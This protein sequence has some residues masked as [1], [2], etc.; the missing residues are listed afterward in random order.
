VS[1][2][3]LSDDPATHPSSHL[4]TP[5]R[6]EL[7]IESCSNLREVFLGVTRSPGPMLESFLD[8]ITSSKLTTITFEF[9]W[10]EYSG[11]DI[12]EIVD[13]QGW[14]G[15]DEALCALVD[16]LSDRSGS[17]PLTVVLSVRAKVDTNLEGAKMGTFLEGFKE[18]GIVRMASFKGF[19][20]PVRP[21]PPLES[22]QSDRTSFSGKIFRHPLGT[23]HV[24]V[25]IK[26]S[27]G[28]AHLYTIRS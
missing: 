10:D 17:D 24:Q 20:Q 26:G 21:H 9:V 14:R 5:G 12:S 22:A 3:Y 7:S 4:G 11:G 1:F 8:S 15:I 19:L 27:I 13:L 18:K 25:G 2:L 28:V 16:R 6:R 23:R